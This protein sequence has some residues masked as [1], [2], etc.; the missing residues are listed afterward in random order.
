MMEETKKEPEAPAAPKKCKHGPREKCLNC[1][2]LDPKQAALVERAC[3]HGPEE[4][5]V[6]CL[7]KDVKVKGIKHTSFEHYVAEI[8][9]KC[10]GLHKDD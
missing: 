4:K 9:K 7:D 6:N 5:C 1:L 8:K 2:S 10:K 3:K